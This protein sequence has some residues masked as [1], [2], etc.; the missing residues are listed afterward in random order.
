MKAIVDEDTCTG[1]ESCVEICP[2]VFEMGDDVA[3]IKS[4]AEDAEFL[5]ANSEGIIQA[6]DEC[7][8]EVIKYET[9]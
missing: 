2:D 5:K 8:T 3:V 4:E 7:P 1:C 6:A 9:D